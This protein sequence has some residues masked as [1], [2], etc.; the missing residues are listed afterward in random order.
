MQSVIHRFV[1][2]LSFGVFSIFQKQGVP[3]A[4]CL[5]QKS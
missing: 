5:H 2:S 4:S 3:R 1:A